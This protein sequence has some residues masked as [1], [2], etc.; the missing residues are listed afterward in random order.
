M[1]L[2]GLPVGPCIVHY[3]QGVLIGAGDED[4]WMLSEGLSAVM[5]HG[6]FLNRN[7]D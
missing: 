1:A 5:Q 2:R 3:K 7:E 4:C 6:G